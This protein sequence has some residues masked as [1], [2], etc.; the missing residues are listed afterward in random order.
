METSAIYVTPPLQ[1]LSD[2][3]IIHLIGEN[4]SEDAFNVFFSRY[5]SYLLR[6]CRE[7]CKG[8]DSSNLLADDIFQQTFLKVLNKSHTFKFKNPDKS[9]DIFKEIKVWLARIARNELINF[10]RKNPDEKLLGNQYRKKSYEVEDFIE[11]YSYEELPVASS[12]KIQKNV[13]DLAL[14]QL[15]EREKFILMSYMELFDPLFPKRH[16]SDDVLKG[17][18]EKFK[19]EPNNVRQIKSRAIKKL[20]K[21]INTN[22]IAEIK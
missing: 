5:K 2:A 8:F 4:K 3:E 17:I 12:Q 15:S 22:I 20:K 9:R 14:S 11:D 13:L 21:L 19:I 10:L 7:C 16:L 1:N 18:C 6:V